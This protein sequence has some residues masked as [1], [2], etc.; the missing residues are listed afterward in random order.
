MH[1]VL[2]LYLSSSLIITCALVKQLEVGEG[3]AAAV[4]VALAPTARHAVQ[5][6]HVDTWSDQSEASKTLYWPIRGQHLVIWTNHNL[7]ILTYQKP[8]IS[9]IDQ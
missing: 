5:P 3:D 8:A 6:A 2:Y 7:V 4:N 1:P 9:H